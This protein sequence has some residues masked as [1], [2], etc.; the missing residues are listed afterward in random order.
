M[1]A[2]HPAGDSLAAAAAP[3]PGWLGAPRWRFLQRVAHVLRHAAAA[4][5]AAAG[6]PGG[7]AGEHAPL[8]ECLSLHLAALQLLE[9]ALEAHAAALAAAAAEPGAPAAAGEAEAGAADLAAAAAGLQDDAASSMAAA[10]AAAAALDKAG[11]EPSPTAVTPA[12]AA[13]AAAEAALPDPWELLYAAALGWGREAAVDELLGSQARSCR[14]YARA[15]TALRCGWRRAGAG[16]P[17]LGCRGRA[18]IEEL[19]GTGGPATAGLPWVRGRHPALQLAVDSRFPSVQWRSFL[20]TEA[21]ALELEPPAELA[22]ADRTRLHQYAAAT[23]VRWAACAA[24]ALAGGGGGPAGDP[25]G[26]P[27]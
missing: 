10:E 26:S 4:R 18:W 20:C 1:F 16:R 3:P 13:A 25:L 21:P 17:L 7:Q 15:G 23:A 6:A 11:R 22:P 12:A 14:L 19:G 5:E 27:M 24:A 2:V 9:H 8:R